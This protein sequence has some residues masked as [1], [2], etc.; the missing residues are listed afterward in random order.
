MR[1]Q[2]PERQHVGNDIAVLLTLAVDDRQ[3]HVGAD[4]LD[5]V[6][7]ELAQVYPIGVDPAHEQVAGL[8]SRLA[9]V[10]RLLGLRLHPRRRLRLVER[11]PEPTLAIGLAIEAD[12]LDPR[13]RQPEGR[14]AP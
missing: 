10:A 3:H 4:E 14:E 8:V 13:R 11:P 2:Y 6:V 1:V 12:S 7:E 5:D 9:A